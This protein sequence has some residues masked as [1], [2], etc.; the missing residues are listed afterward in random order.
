[1]LGASAL[2]FPPTKPKVLIMTYEIFLMRVMHRTGL[3]ER[4]ST[5]QLIHH[6][7]ER[8]AHCLPMPQAEAVAQGLPDPLATRMR[9]CAGKE[10][11]DLDSLYH[12]VAERLGM[13]VSF[14]LEFTQVVLQVLGESVGRDG[15]AELRSLLPQNWSSLFEPRQARVV[16]L[17]SRTDSRSTLSSGEPGSSHPLSQARPGHR[18]SIAHTDQPHLGTKLS[19]SHGKPQRRTLATG[20]PGSSRPLSDSGR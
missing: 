5:E 4:H 14:G 11:C 10:P 15:R 9:D 12:S 2:S 7:V 3:D 8:L 1:M 18:N 20:R 13:D 16:P 19:T 17:G 6:V